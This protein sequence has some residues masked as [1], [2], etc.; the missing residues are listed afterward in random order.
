M[1]NKD[2]LFEIDGFRV[3]NDTKYTVRDKIDYDAPSG[4]VESGVSRLPSDG[5]GDTF[6]C[7][8]A[9]IEPGSRDGI[10]DTGF[11]ESSKCYSNLSSKEAKE[12]AKLAVKNVMEPFAKRMG[13]S[14]DKL[15]QDSDNDFW[16]N[17]S[18]RVYS[19]QVMNTRKVEDRFNLYFALLTGHLAPEEDQGNSIYSKASYIVIDIDKGTKRKDEKAM[20]QFEAISSFMETLKRDRN[21]VSS[22]LDYIGLSVS[23]S[24][25]DSTVMSMFKEFIEQ[26]ESKLKLYNKVAKEAKTKSGREKLAIYKILKE[27]FPSKGVSKSENGVYFFSGEEIGGDL[28]TAA[29][30][31]AT[32]SQFSDIKKELV[33]EDD[34]D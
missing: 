5:V 20:L 18:F 9:S 4:F 30:N 13:S 26:D 24:A 12:R 34:E 8:F 11:Y 10:W 7:G 21:E 2:L 22:T 1:K 27:R 16:D 33:L 19:G 17:K 25:A 29:S 31:I 23:D 15:T 6:N 14:T 3:Y 32:Q 28:K